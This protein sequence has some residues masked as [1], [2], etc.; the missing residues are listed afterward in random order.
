MKQLMFA[1]GLSLLT[2]PACQHHPA[3]GPAQRAGASVDDAA[4]KTKDAA[5][6]AAHDVKKKADG[7]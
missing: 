4:Q 3:E 2:L 7:E 5:K 6:D 1:L